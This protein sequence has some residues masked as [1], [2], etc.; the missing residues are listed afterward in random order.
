M[1]VISV[2]MSAYNEKVPILK[3]SIESILNQ[4]F[5]D[6][7]FII[8]V[9]NPDNHEAIQLIRKYSLDDSRIRFYINKKNCGQSFS[10]NTGIRLAE[11]GYIARQD[12]DDESLPQRLDKQYKKI[13][14]N[15]LIDVVGTAVSYIY[16][17]EDSIFIRYYKESVDREIKRYCPVA[18][19]T[20]LIKKELFEK[21][22]Y[23]DETGTLTPTEDYELWCRWYLC[24]VQFYNL[25]EPLYKY[26]QGHCTLKSNKTKKQLLNT[27]KIKWRYA[28]R[29]GFTFLDYI[30]MICETIVLLLPSKLIIKYFYSFHQKYERKEY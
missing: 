13:I 30:Y 8:I 26:Y 27:I 9:D 10:L 14:S 19:P 3:R 25:K 6:F 29:F 22:G 1:A 2:V 4:T 12:A 16:G 18:H 28:S 7:E 17:N 15:Q 20:L 11:G 21:F 24:K 23:Y 5:K